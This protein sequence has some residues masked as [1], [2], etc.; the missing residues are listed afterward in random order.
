MG[1]P[2]AS[3]DPAGETSYFLYDAARQRTASIDPLG[4]PSYFYYDL[5]GRLEGHDRC[6]GRGDLLRLR[7]ERQPAS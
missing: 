6:P 4:N 1:L 2:I 7:R 3:I 5:A